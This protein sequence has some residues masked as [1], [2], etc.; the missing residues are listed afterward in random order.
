MK[1]GRRTFVYRIKMPGGVV[2]V[3]GSEGERRGV[4]VV[5]GDGK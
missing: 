1:G 2:L 5:V 3:V 4:V